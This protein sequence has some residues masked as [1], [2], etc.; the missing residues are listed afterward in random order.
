[1]SVLWGLARD[2]EIHIWSSLL[3]FL[4]VENLK[5]CVSVHL[6]ACMCQFDSGKQASLVFSCFASCFV[7]FLRYQ[8]ALVYAV[9]GRDRCQWCAC[10]VACTAIGAMRALHSAH[11]P[12]NRG[13][14]QACTRT[15]HYWC[16]WMCIPASTGCMCQ[17]QSFVL[18]SIFSHNGFLNSLV[19]SWGA[20]ALLLD[21]L[22]AHEA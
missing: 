3:L 14:G 19:P 5:A 2:R 15:T 7:S 8:D 4:F 17:L 20:I 10:P 22:V 9:G 13:I 16:S 18:R 12:N 1:M 21:V 6:Y 11:A